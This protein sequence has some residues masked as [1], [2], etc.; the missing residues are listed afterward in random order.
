MLKSNNLVSWILST[1]YPDDVFYIVRV[2]LLSN[3]M[4][5]ENL[6]KLLSSSHETCNVLI[7]KME[8]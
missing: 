4:L 8:L 7:A 1:E 6:K 3:S 5:F 2:L